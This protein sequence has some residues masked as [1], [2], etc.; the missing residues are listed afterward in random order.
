MACRPEAITVPDISDM[1]NDQLDLFRL[2][3]AF[4]MHLGAANFEAHPP[5]PRT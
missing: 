4:D 5:S 2:D 1:F 3:S